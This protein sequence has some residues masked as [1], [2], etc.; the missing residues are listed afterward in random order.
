M[1]S[2]YMMILYDDHIWWS[3][4]LIIY[5][6]HM[7]SSYMILLTHYWR[8]VLFATWKHVVVSVIKSVENKTSVL[9]SSGSILQRNTLK[10]NPFQTITYNPHES[11]FPCGVPLRNRF[12]TQPMKWSYGPSVVLVVL[13]W[14]NHENKR[15]LFLTNYFQIKNTYR[16]VRVYHSVS[17]DHGVNLIIVESSGHY[18]AI[19]LVSF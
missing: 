1:R 3:F 9:L 12:F 5:D 8:L 18:F 13:F 10:V 15:Y 4:T 17:G 11:L 16:H 6:L 2:S 19:V 7:W 14:P